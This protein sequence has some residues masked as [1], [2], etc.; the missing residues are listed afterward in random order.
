MI[1]LLV[2]YYSGLV[3]LVILKCYRISWK[4]YES[5]DP[6]AKRYGRNYFPRWP[7][8]WKN[9]ALNSSKSNQAVAESMRKTARYIIV[10]QK[11][12]SWSLRTTTIWTCSRIFY[13]QFTTATEVITTI[14]GTSCIPKTSKRMDTGATKTVAEMN[15]TGVD[16]WRTV[17]Q[18]DRESLPQSPWVAPEIQ[19]LQ[20]IASHF[21]LTWNSLPCGQPTKAT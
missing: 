12:K 5:E 10:A 17:L 16:H 9:R 18:T 19:L 8:S 13:H 14:D 7:S 11:P 1:W 4:L 15:V 21:N 6:P 20:K 2:T 3:W